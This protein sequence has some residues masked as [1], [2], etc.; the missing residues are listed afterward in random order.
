MTGRL[1][2]VRSPSPSPRSTAG[3]SLRQREKAANVFV[4]CFGESTLNDSIES[5][6]DGEG[7]AAAFFRGTGPID[8]SSGKRTSSAQTEL[9]VSA[10][11]TSARVFM[12]PLDLLSRLPSPEVR[13]PPRGRV[14]YD[15]ASR[16]P[17]AAV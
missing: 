9:T 8:A 11:S 3:S 13:R 10:F 2:N 12:A 4:E 7:R 6:P 14:R 17:L 1:L 5:L 15:A 16:S